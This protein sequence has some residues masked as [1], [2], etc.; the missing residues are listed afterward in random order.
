MS[1]P[2]NLMKSIWL[3]IALLFVFGRVVADPSQTNDGDDDDV[4]L[5]DLD[6]YISGQKDVTEILQTHPQDLLNALKHRVRS[7]A[8]A[9]NGQPDQYLFESATDDYAFVDS[10]ALEEI[11]K[12][13]SMCIGQHIDNLFHL[14]AEMISLNSKI[15]PPPTELTIYLSLIDHTITYYSSFRTWCQA[16]DR[17]AKLLSVRN[18]IRTTS[19]SSLIGDELILDRCISALLADGFETPER[20]FPD[21]SPQGKCIS[22]A[23]VIA[24]IIRGVIPSFG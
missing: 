5:I 16:M 8:S 17:S 20:D 6:Q 10:L 14:V 19:I 2:C 21:F 3:A 1:V 7:I 11:I 23:K 13:P 22:H 4:E 9:G 12:V 24:K 15:V 18:R